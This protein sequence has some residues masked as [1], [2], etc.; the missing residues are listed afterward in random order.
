[1]FQAPPGFIPTREGDLLNVK[2]IGSVCQI[3]PIPQTRIV[4]HSTSYDGKFERKPTTAETYYPG[5]PDSL[6]L[7]F[8]KPI[9]AV[10]CDNAVWYFQMSVQQ[11]AARMFE[12]LHELKM[13]EK[14]G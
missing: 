7:D 5:F 11:F 9:T 1:M 10:T 6:G 12:A 4:H 14:F 3:K 8:S 2:N 13:V